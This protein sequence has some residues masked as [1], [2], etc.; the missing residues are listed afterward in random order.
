MGD[1]HG[2][3]V[4]GQGADLVEAFDGDAG[5]S[6]AVFRLGGEEG[7]FAGEGDGVGDEAAFGGEGGPGGVDEAGVVDAATEEDGVGGG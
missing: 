4:G 7:S 6:A 5:E 3:A 2:G 1:G